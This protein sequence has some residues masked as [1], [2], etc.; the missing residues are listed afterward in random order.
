MGP[1]INSLAQKWGINKISVTSEPI[2]IP[3][4]MEVDFKHL[5]LRYALSSLHPLVPNTRLAHS[6]VSEKMVIAWMRTHLQ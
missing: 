1:S 2:L 5:S 6:R 4:P 3:E